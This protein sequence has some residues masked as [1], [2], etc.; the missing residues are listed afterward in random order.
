MTGIPGFN[1]EV[2]TSL[3][4]LWDGDTLLEEALASGRNFGDVLSELQT[5]LAAAS[6]AF[7]ADPL[8]SRFLTVTTT[9]ELEYPAGGGG[10][11]GP[12]KLTDID[13]PDPKR[14]Q[15]A[16]HMLP[17]ADWGDAVGWSAR[18]LRRLRESKIRADVQRAVDD[19]SNT[20]RQQALTRLFKKEADSVGST[21]S[22]SQ[23]FADGGDAGGTYT[24]P[25]GREGKTFASSHDHYARVSGI[26]DAN[27]E[28][29]LD[30]LHEHNHAGPY[31][32]I[33]SNTAADKTTWSAL[34]GF[35]P[36]SN[37][38]IKYSDT[39][40]RLLPGGSGDVPFFGVYDGDV[41]MANIWTSDRVPT[42]YWA[43]FKSYGANHPRN[44]VAM[45]VD[46]LYGF[47]WQVMPG[48]WVNMP[49][50]LAAYFFPFGFGVND[51]TAAYLYY[52]AGAGDYVTPTIT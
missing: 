37:D 22:A 40:T 35:V 26:T 44:P 7:I 14:G 51:R 19:A 31:D 49:L 16:G 23:P 3:P 47:G 15:T 27:V 13:T 2:N 28:A 32:I 11:S 10:G 4:A 42:L 18:S 41:G 29:G 36:K 5:A 9:R 38:G 45:L 48:Q 1:L 30:H 8:Y 6:A 52:N 17:R 50:V 21:A 25:V 20:L 12:I 34:S 39:V 24:P 46:P 43:A 33:I